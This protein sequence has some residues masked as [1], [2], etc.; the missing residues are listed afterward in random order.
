MPLNKLENFIKNVEGRILYVN[1]N[2]LD[3]T[4]NINN[5]GNSLAQPFKTVQR[6]LLESARFSYLK[7]NNNDVTEK[8]TILLFPG[9]HTVDNRPGYAIKDIAGTAYA[10]SPLG[11]QTAASA[12][13][14][15]DLNS[16]FDITSS[17]NILYKFNSIRGGVIVPRG[18]SIVSLDL[19]KTKIRP[20][21]IPNPT[22]VDVDPSAIFRITGACY[23]WQLSFFDGDENTLVYTDSRDFSSGNRSKPTFSH[24]KLTCFEYADGTNVP[25]G[26][27]ISD[28]DMYYSKLS[29]AFNRASGRDID[30]KFPSNS[31]GFSKQRP[32]WEIVGAFAPDPIPISSITS[33]DGFTPSNLVTVTTSEPHGL[34]AGTPVKINGIDVEDYNISTKVQNVNS[35]FQFTYLLPFVRNNLPASP[36]VSGAEV[37]IETDTVSG[38]SP[39]IFNVSLRSVWGMNGM[40]A[41]GSKASGFKSMVVA[42]FTGVSLQKDDRAFV[43]YNKTSRKYESITVTKTSGSELA[44]GSSSTNP[45][46]AYHLDSD[47]IYRDGWESSHV[48]VTNDA[49]VQVVSVFAIG[50]TKHFDS[51]TGGDISITNSNSNFGQLALSSYGFRKEAF[52]KDDNAYIT[53]I[54]TPRAI[55][56]ETSLIDWQSFDV[57]LTTSVGISSHLYLY[58]FTEKQD[59][60][61]V[62]VQAF[63]VGAKVDDKIFVSANG[64]NYSASINM[65]DSFINNVAYGSNVSFKEYYVVSGPSGSPSNILNIGTHNLSTGEKILILSDDGDI[66][67]N[68]TENVIYYAIRHSS[69]EI[70]IAAS[71][72][73]TDNGTAITIYGGSKVKIVSRVSDKNAG[74]VGS[75]VQYDDANSNWFLHVNPNNDIYNIFNTLGEASLTDRSEVSYFE[76][77]S[78]IRSLDEKIYKLRVVIPKESI[79]A[80]DPTEG[81]VIQESNSTGARSEYDFTL[82]NITSND[83]AYNKNLRLISKCSQTS[84]IVTVTTEKPHNLSVGDTVTIKNVQSS[85]N[86]SG[87][88]NKGFNGLFT[89]LSVTGD[90][91]FTYSIVDIEGV[92]HNTGTFVDNTSTRNVFLPRFERID[93]KKN[94]YIYRSDTI[95][96]YIYNVQDGIYHLYVLN[97]DNQIPEEFSDLKFSQPVIDLYPQFDRDNIEENPQPTKCFAKRSPVGDVVTNDVKKSVTKETVDKMAVSL[98]FGLKI[99]G[100][101]TTYTSATSGTTTLVFDRPHNLSGIVTYSSISRGSGYTPGTYYNVK[102]YNTGT[103]TWDGAT[104]KVVVAGAANSITSVDIMTGGSGYTNGEVLEFDTTVVGSGSGASITISHS[105][106]SSAINNVI[107]T[108]G[109]TTTSDGYFRI[110][111]IPSTTQVSVAITNGDPRIQINQYAFNVGKSL[112]VSSSSYNSSNGYM[113]FNCSSSHGLLIGNRIRIIDSNNN[114][115]G[116]YIVNEITSLT[117]FRSLTNRS[118]SASRIFKHGLSANESTSDIQG[119]NLGIRGQY[120]YDN[121]RLNLITAVTTENYLEVETLES[122]TAILNRFPLGSY[123]QIGNEIMRIT[124]STLSGSNLNLIYVI[125]G[126]LGT[127]IE[128]HS[129]NSLIQKIKPIAIELRRPAIIRAS[130]HTFEY[131]GYGPGNYSTSLPQL[132]VKT[133]TERE[134]FLSQSQEKSSGIVVYTGMNSDGDF[135]IGNT[136]YSSTSGKQKTFDI[137][138]PTVTG[139]DPSRLSVVF[140]EVT[141]KERLLVEGGNSGTILSQFNGP[142]LMNKDLKINGAVNINNSLK[143]RDSLKIDST[144]QS[145][146]KDTGCL[147]VEGGVGI[148]KNLNV[149][150]ATSITG[151][152]RVSGVSTFVGVS[153]FNSNIFVGG[154]ASLVGSL[155]VNSSTGITLRNGGDLILN[156]ASNSGSASIYCDTDNELRTNNNVYIGGA[157]NVV[158][159]ITAFYSSDKRLKN[160][161]NPIPNALDKV[162]SISGNTFTWNDNSSHTGE[163][164]G[165]IAQEVESILPQ[166]VKTRGDGYKAVQYEKL[167]PLLIEAIKDLNNKLNSINNQSN[168]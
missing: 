48:K 82:T 23:F 46:S 34:T 62:V 13:L 119:E 163:D 9:E 123:I 157:L 29:N 160:N 66:P 110:T 56:S 71:K 49:F 70:K 3:A 42:Q 80:K 14:T 118:L 96:S 150:G 55:I 151:L 76:R 168:K 161:I 105:G 44:S 98:G 129:A 1:P 120:I 130:G 78:D 131:L 51:Q 50:F 7:G 152:L 112:V 141:I 54:I 127:Q 6:A 137:P 121:E 115:L 73:N 85:T 167:V 144:T 93:L 10:I 2:D 53:S 97:A 155:T 136:K 32:E 60:P 134:E 84:N 94:F 87:E 158:G 95:S 81:Y 109:I 4:D 12:E 148:E 142:V 88:N 101:S 36:S 113:T 111:S 28:L 58:G 63:K 108:T 68:L 135:F 37:T 79:N 25:T 31:L 128:S 52:S 106:I 38:A 39:Y 133:L 107:Q 126:A 139:Q 67:E 164:V 125:R 100:V 124:S 61:P 154:D 165:V 57:G 75:P 27:D 102:L 86:A 99:T 146:D 74:D 162:N 149:G 159:D 24:H 11:E 114:N 132:Q 18:T 22:D 8:T 90:K 83:Y 43:K 166:V 47:A 20:K 15:L 140:D 30:Q 5:Q 69:T 153:T 156:N 104:S 92:T 45:N 138:T 40:L 117:S 116:D 17:D 65:V 26:Y 59:L 89:V 147:V 103:S 35:L 19:R 145:V 72:T 41:D 21:Y 16:N 64:N 77:N 33:G 91:S 143:V 122:Q